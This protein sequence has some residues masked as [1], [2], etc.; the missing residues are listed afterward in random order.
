MEVN[1]TALLFK[2]LSSKFGHRDDKV[3]TKFQFNP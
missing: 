2:F 1:Q 3:V